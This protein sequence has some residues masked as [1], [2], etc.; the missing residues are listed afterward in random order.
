[1]AIKFKEVQ[2]VIEIELDTDMIETENGEKPVLIVKHPSNLDVRF[3]YPKLGLKL[4]ETLKASGLTEEELRTQDIDSKKFAFLEEMVKHQFEVV[5][6]LAIKFKGEAA[7]IT[8]EELEYINAAGLAP[9]INEKLNAE[10][11]RLNKVEAEK[12]S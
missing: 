9:Q 5:K 11:E 6:L 2:K 4:K 8:S 7:N 12:K 3:E 10:L 1:M